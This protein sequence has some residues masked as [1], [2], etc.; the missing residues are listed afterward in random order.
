MVEGS[1]WGGVFEMIMSFDLIIV[2]SILIFLMTFV[3]F[4]VSYNLV[5]IY[6][7][8]RDAGFYIVKELIFIVSL[9][10][11]QRALVVGIFN[12]VVE[13]EELEDFIL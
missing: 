9:I 1:V 2:V 4:G 8:I 13:V 5:G 11:V 7:L 3:N 6:N 12:Y 10:I